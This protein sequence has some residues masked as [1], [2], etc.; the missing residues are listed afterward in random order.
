VPCDE[1]FFILRSARVG[2]GIVAG[3]NPIVVDRIFI[4][5]NFIKEPS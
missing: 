1:E 2:K 4:A 3:R 5:E